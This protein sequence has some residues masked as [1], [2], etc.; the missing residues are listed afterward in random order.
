MV[1]VA[2]DHDDARAALVRLLKLDGYEAVGVGTGADALRFLDTNLP[3]L[4][5]LDYSMPGMD[6]LTVYRAMRADAR[7]SRVPVIMFSAFDGER[8]EALA[9]GIAAYVQKGTLDWA[10]LRKEIAR[11]AGPADAAA[12]AREAP[13]VRDVECQPGARKTAG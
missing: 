7:L 1:L 3:R 12:P 6:G 9:E 8:V 13:P 4:V 5:I 2:D 10:V 11:V